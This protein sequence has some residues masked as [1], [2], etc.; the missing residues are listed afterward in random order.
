MAHRGA[1]AIQNALRNAE[2]V[3]AGYPM[4]FVGTVQPRVSDTIIL[5]RA[6]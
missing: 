2:S 4:A 3:E 6:Q 5:T 1:D